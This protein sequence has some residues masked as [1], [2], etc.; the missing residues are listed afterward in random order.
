MLPA[1]G[2]LQ[3]RG[4]AF[5]IFL[6]PTPFVDKGSLAAFSYFVAPG[7]PIVGQLNLWLMSR[8]L[9]RN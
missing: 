1:E 7:R 9:G 8:R 3:T 5:A 2:P 6:W 4:C